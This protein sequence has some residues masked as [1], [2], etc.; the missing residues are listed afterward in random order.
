MANL[1]NNDSQSLA[2]N[3]DSVAAEIETIAIRVRSGTKTKLDKIL[4][5][6]NSKE[7]GKRVKSDDVISFA[8]GL[9]ND[10]YMHSLRDQS[11]TNSDRLEILFQQ[12][13]KRKKELT[14]DEF[15]G[16]L[17]TGQIST[18][19]GLSMKCDGNPVQTK[20]VAEN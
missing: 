20:Q 3:D 18:L 11:L 5:A 9:I 6:V 14:K 16:L 10:A 4:D 17:M 12:Q 19:N 8:I 2:K 7:Y 13:R 1:T 15:L